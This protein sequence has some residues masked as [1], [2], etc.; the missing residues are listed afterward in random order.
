MSDNPYRTYAFATLGTNHYGMVTIW[1]MLGSRQY[2]FWVG[3]N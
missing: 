3:V 2:C 1:M